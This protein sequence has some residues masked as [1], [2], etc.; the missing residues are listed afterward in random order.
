MGMP[1]SGKR[2]RKMGKNGASLVFRNNPYGVFSRPDI[3]FS[4]HVIAYGEP[5]SVNGWNGRLFRI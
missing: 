3:P 4:Y 2:E 1:D 5:T